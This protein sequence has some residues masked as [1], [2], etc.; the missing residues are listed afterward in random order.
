MQ[1]ISIYIHTNATHKNFRV[2]TAP[3]AAPSREHWRELIAG[4]DSVYTSSVDAFR[5]VLVIKGRADVLDQ[6]RII[7]YDGAE[8]AVSLP[9]PAYAISLGTNVEFDI[10][11]LR[12]EYNSMVTP[13]TVFDYHLADRRLETLKVREI[14]SGYDPTQYVT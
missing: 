11:R 14:P 12:L 13:D 8:H 5:H 1:G 6:I 2:A 7:D 9:E 4:S 3:V 10:D